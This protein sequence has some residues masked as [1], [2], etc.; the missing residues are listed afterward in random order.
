MRCVPTS[1][2]SSG[3]IRL[4]V[5]HFRKNQNGAIAPLF[6]LMLPPILFAM[7]LAIDT[8]NLMRVR[9]NVQNSLDAAALAVGK[10]YTVASTEDE[11]RTFGKRI[12]DANLRAIEPPA[13]KFNL[14]FPQGANVDQQIV[15]SASFRY[16]SFFGR[17]VQALSRGEADWDK[18]T[19]NMAATVRLKNTL[20]VALVLDN[21][22]SMDERGSG[23]G[24]QRMKLLQDAASQLVT[25]MAKQA[26]L[27]TH[28]E[29][30]IQFSLVPF[31]GSVN[32]GANN[33][34]RTW[35]DQ[36]GVSPVHY[37]NFT[38]PIRNNPL[39]VGRNKNIVFRDNAY[40]KEGTGWGVEAGH[41]FTRFSLYE[42]MKTRNGSTYASWQ[43][44]V[45][46]R[47]GLYGIN[48]D[49]PSVTRPET[50]YVP[51]F[52]PSEFVNSTKALNSWW[53][54]QANIKGTSVSSYQLRQ[55]DLIRYYTDTAASAENLTLTGAKKIG[56]NYSCTTTPITELTDVT[57]SVGMKKIQDGIKNMVPHGG[58]NVPEGMV[59]GWRTLM[60]NAPFKGGRPSSERGNDKVVIVLTDG[61]NTYY[62]YN[63]LGNPDGRTTTD[64]AGNTSY[65]SGLG[66]VGTNTPGYNLPRIFQATTGVNTNS[67]N[68][69]NY[70]NALNARFSRLCELAKSSNIM[71]MTVALDLRQSNTTDRKQMEIMKECAS[72]SRVRFDKD[73]PTRR[74]KLF[75]NTTGSELEQTFREIADEL[76]NLR[77]VQ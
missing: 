68:N 76:S 48:A 6:A 3:R 50:M 26:E 30:P 71:V 46:T 19:Y 54:D 65:Y 1:G 8:A 63:G 14:S 43:G 51:M 24:Q 40:F 75:W 35:M 16:V 69:D 25:N 73:Y 10:R 20:E 52:A 17:A 56:P 34:D 42:D 37:E 61:A 53:P 36:T 32:I 77:V 60:Q 18:Y 7:M 45:E 28:L 39:V 58:T 72:E 66:Y 38:M 5:R 41:Y 13:T 21:S 33:R 49:V 62:Q 15:A 55:S 12:F 11:M 22:G 9:G 29:N 44:C 70:T 64:R 74:A 57:T 59:W 47:P 4:F 2:N 67:R 31:A 27:I 23:S